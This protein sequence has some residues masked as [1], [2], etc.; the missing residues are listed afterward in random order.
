MSL[1]NLA[2]VAVCCDVVYSYFFKICKKVGFS[3]YSKFIG[4]C[5]VIKHFYYEMQNGR[6]LGVVRGILLVVFLVGYSYVQLSEG[7]PDHLF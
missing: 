7:S 5:H 6:P 2:I 3:F 1:D 4:M